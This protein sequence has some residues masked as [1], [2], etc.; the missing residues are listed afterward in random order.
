MT[1][2]VGR[3]TVLVVD[4]DPDVLRACRRAWG[5]SWNV[6][7]ASDTTT[8]VE[9]AR[10]EPVAIAIVDLYLGDARGVD[11]LAAIKEIR[12]EAY[13]ALVS[14]AMTF[15]WAH[16]AHVADVVLD[17]P[18]RLEQIVARRRD[19]ERWKTEHSRAA[20]RS[21]DEVERE[22]VMRVLGECDGN[23]ARAARLLGI[24]VARLQR[25]TSRT[26]P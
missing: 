16:H 26:G 19:P 17:K 3:E 10:R 23:K 14:G 13:A 9:L 15:D 11:V 21:L 25:I 18:V 1:E 2:V 4:D 22:H 20:T 8:A 7:V 5:R 6:L 24:S 12:P